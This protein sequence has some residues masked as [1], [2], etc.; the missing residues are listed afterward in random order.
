[1]VE[2]GAEALTS[3]PAQLT[4]AH[5]DDFK[6]GRNESLAVVNGNTV[7]I[8]CDAPYSNPPPFIHFYKDG[9]SIE[10]ETGKLRVDLSNT[11]IRAFGAYQE[12]LRVT[13]FYYF[14]N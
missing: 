11:I 7:A 5:I 14:W 8:P 3:V 12:I 13:V 9:K 6:P 10:S 4:M 1:V 2:F